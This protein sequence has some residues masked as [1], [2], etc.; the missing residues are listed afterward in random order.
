MGL[1]LDTRKFVE[2]VN[3]AELSVREAES[4]LTSEYNLTRFQAKPAIATAVDQGYVKIRDTKRQT[5]NVYVLAYPKGQLFLR[6][7]LKVPYGV[8]I[9]YLNYHSLIT[10]I[11][12]SAVTSL[13][14]LLIG[15]ALD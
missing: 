10:T 7:R 5:G 11:I 2:F 9:E 1:F 14:V 8:I 15:S 6:R 3:V 4:E 12:V 13:V